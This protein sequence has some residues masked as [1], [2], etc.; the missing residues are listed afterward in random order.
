M[1]LHEPANAAAVPA[2]AKPDLIQVEKLRA[3]Y[4][5]KQVVFDVDLHVRE[6]EIVSIV[7]ANG[8]GKTTTLKT[9]YGMLPPLGGTVTYRGENTTRDFATQNAARGMSLIPAER[10]VFGDLTVRDNL[11]LGALH[12]KSNVVR[13]SRWKRVHDL[14]P[15]LAERSAQKAGTMSGGQPRKGSNAP[16]HP[17]VRSR[18]PSSSKFSRPSANSPAK[19]ASPCS[20]S[21]RTSAKRYASP[22]AST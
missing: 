12:E 6:G 21:S 15:I 18:R 8:A 11:L 22:T 7:G 20:S 19:R 13:E 1:E 10:F 2:A 5:R 3:G 4:G 14:F 9:I 16:R 17:A